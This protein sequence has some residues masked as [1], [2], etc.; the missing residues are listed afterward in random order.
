MR[1]WMALMVVLATVMGSAAAQQ[2]PAGPEAPEGPRVREYRPRP[3]ANSTG[4]TITIP[5]DT[6][7]PLVLKQPISTKNARVGDGV[8]AQTNFPITQNDRVV[9]PVGTYVQGVITNIKRAGRVKG[10]AEVQFHFT[11]MIFRNGY[12][13]SLPGSVEAVP[14][15]ENSKTTGPEGTVQHEGEKGKD[16]GQVAGTAATGAAIGG[17]AAQSAKGAGIGAGVG[18]A[19]GLALAMLTRGGDVRLENGT[20]VEMVIS[21]PITLDE[22][23]LP[24]VG[25]VGPVMIDE[26]RF[27]R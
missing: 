22:N 7:V 11:S 18:G 5:A 6:K 8:Y 23:R 27:S 9:I 24:R 25:P 2:Q 21:R 16:I 14:G 10:R 20:S 26:S 19:A 12:T 15:A 1:F 13:V 17:I 4:G 3:A